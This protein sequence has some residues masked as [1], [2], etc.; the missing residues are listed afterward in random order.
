MTNQAVTGDPIAQLSPVASEVASNI[1]NDLRAGNHHAARFILEE[2]TGFGERNDERGL[3][4]FAQLLKH[5]AEEERDE[6]YMVLRMVVAQRAKFEAE[7]RG[8]E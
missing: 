3:A 5:V 1:F 4:A 6:A 2:F 7:A 8:L